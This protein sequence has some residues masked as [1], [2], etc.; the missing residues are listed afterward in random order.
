MLL[1][2][3]VLLSACT[4]EDD[5]RRG[6]SEHAGER[7]LFR[8]SL[9]E[10][11]TRAAEITGVTLPY[12]HVTAFN[13]ADPELVTNGTL[14]THF[15]NCRIDITDGP[16]KYSSDECIWPAMGRESDEVT[17]FAF[18]PSLTTLDEK[19]PCLPAIGEIQNAT[20]I[21]GNNPNYN[22]RL[23]KFSVNPEIA[24]QV[25]FVTAYTTGNMATHLF[26]GITLPFCH[27]LSRI[28]VKAWSA[29]KSCDIEIAGVRIGGIGVEG[30]FTFK[31]DTQTGKLES[32]KGG[33]EWE[34]ASII[35]GIVE[36]IYRK[37]DTV[38]SLKHGA[39]EKTSTNAGAVSIM[40]SKNGDDENCA[41]LIPRNYATG[42]KF[43]E[44]PHNS[45][46]N[47]YIGVLLRVTD[48]THTAGTNPEEPQRFPYKDLSQGANSPNI[49]VVYLAV[50]ESTGEV[51]T[52]LYKSGDNYYTDE[53]TTLPYTLPEDEV[54]KE[55]GWATL[56]VTGNWAP[57]NIYTYTLDYTSGVGL[58]GPE[59]AD[60]PENPNALPKA[61]DPIISDK[62]GFSYSVKGWNNG[63]G[64]EFP[65]P[66][67]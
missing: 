9:P 7:I 24:D 52:R 12:F 1:G 58:H 2:A 48:I 8:A 43:A 3:V 44:D 39:T 53:A 57:G 37:G 15:G 38:V 62:V 59:V 30:T 4:Q 22:Y 11:A 27:Q 10:V 25:D 67:S 13:P 6:G 40:G 47:M 33:G 23:T 45:G 19:P 5:I 49:P 42:W 64:S 60:H 36:Y 46:Q 18:Y 50:K 21:T 56:P 28:E 61:G 29:N 63:G 66:G 55:F 26:S 32:A 34:D 14:G 31:P 65:V 17:F 51:S 16:G 35:P 41:M 20:T 54:V